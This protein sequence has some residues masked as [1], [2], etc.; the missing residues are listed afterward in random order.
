MTSTHIL[1]G[2]FSRRDTEEN[3]A[4]YRTCVEHAAPDASV[5]LCFFA[6]EAER[7]D[8]LFHELA[9]RFREAGAVGSI[10]LATKEQFKEQLAQARLVY[11]H[12]GHTP[13]L[14]AAL[15]TTGT[16]RMS[17]TGKVVA[18][19]S[20][21]AYAL[22]AFGTSHSDTTVRQG[23]ACVPVRL[24]CHHE[25]AELPPNPDSLAQ[26]LSEHKELPVVYLKDGA[27]CVYPTT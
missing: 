20:A 17:L 21:G 10:A 4:F 14:L 12:G 11:F 18:G 7:V 25:S 6:A 2:G 23:L 15:R 26:L 1:H 3:R 27:H 8:D 19:S 16:T 9:M 24:V 5:L 13:T 22:A